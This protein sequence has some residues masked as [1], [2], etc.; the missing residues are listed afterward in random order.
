M[1]NCLLKSKC[2]QAGNLAFCGP[3]CYAF[4]KLQGETGRGGIWGL[5]G[6]PKTYAGVT[7]A[8][9]PFEQDNPVACTAVQKY[10]ADVLGKV[11]KGCGLYLFSI[12]Q[13]DNPKGTG[14][15]KTTAAVAI[16]NEFMVAR[17]IQ[18][19]KKER[20]IDEI[21]ALF[22]N[23][24]KYQNAF[25]AQFRGTPEMQQAASYQYYKLKR[26]MLRA[27]LLVLDDIG[28]REA[29]EAY[30][31]EFYEVIDGRII[32]GMTSIYTSNLPL[33]EIAGL[34][35]DR[36]ASRIEGAAIPVSFRGV[37]HRKAGLF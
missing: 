13:L 24:S 5:A 14:T 28:V 15:G 26:R 17:T 10:C 6:I 37:D 8:R 35:D 2:K 27:E 25:N 23:A 21:P 34:L 7:A 18:H 3:L 22:V 29:T 11:A 36:I 9:L 30:R 4:L 19:V 33:N 1:D 31:S 12:P 16:L 20:Q 32:E